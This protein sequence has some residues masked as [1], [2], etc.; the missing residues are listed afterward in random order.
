MESVFGMDGGNPAPVRRSE[1]GPG[2]GARVGR[3]ATRLPG[4]G[5]AGDAFA[6]FRT[7]RASRQERYE[8]EGAMG[9]RLAADLRPEKRAETEGVLA[10]SLS[11]RR[12]SRARAERARS[13]NQALEA[14]P[15]CRGA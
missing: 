5:S 14:I 12:Q 7:C 4:S 1:Q 9:P 13:C 15:R 6:L 10:E 11:H 8:G 3:G 2:V